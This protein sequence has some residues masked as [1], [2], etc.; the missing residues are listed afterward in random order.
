MRPQTSIGHASMLCAALG[1][2]RADQP[3]KAPAIRRAAR[4]AAGKYCR[5]RQDA[6]YSRFDA[7]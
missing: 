4:E 5:L 2:Q 7:G 6:L 3:S 1:P